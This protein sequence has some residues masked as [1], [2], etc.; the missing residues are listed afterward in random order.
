MVATVKGSASSSLALT[1]TGAGSAAGAASVAESAEAPHFITDRS[2]ALRL[3]YKNG[4]AEI[5]RS[6]VNSIVN[7]YEKQGV[8]QTQHVGMMACTVSTKK[9]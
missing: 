6:W 9:A 7:R 1:G 5:P 8:A 4:E 2:R 3:T